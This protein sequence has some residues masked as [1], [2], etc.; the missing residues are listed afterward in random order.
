MKFSLFPAEHRGLEL[1]RE[2][3]S[4][5][6]DGVQILSQMLGAAEDELD[7]LAASLGS[8]E[9]RATDRHY[10][11]LTHLRSSYVNP[12][13]REDIYTFSRLLHEAVEQLSGAGD[14]IVHTAAGR[15]S[16]RAAEQLETIGRQAELAAAAIGQLNNLD[17]L[18]DTWLEMV[19]L[20]K[21]ASR[22]HR[23]WVAELSNLQKASAIVKHR[24]VADQLLAAVRSLRAVADHL[25]RILVKES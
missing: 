10:A 25:G 4:E 6:L 23:V 24:Y 3:S 16:R 15:L 1:L 7:G 13:P 5:V 17:D 9:A 19:R 2:L 18:E 8:T 21:R 20:S 22:T 12:L 14:L 11:V